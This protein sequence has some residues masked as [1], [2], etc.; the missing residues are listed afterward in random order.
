MTDVTQQPTQLMTEAA[1]NLPGG[2]LVCEQCDWVVLPPSDVQG[3]VICPNCRQAKL[4]PS[5]PRPDGRQ[6]YLR[7]AELTAPFE[8]TPAAVQDAVQQFSRDIPYPPPDLTAANLQSRLQKVFLPAWL[9]DASV[10]AEWQAEVGFN[11]QVVSHQERYSDGADWKTQEV[12]EDRVRWEPRRGRLTRAYQNVRAPALEDAARLNDAIGSY[13]LENIRQ[14]HPSDRQGAFVRL[15]NRSPEDAWV[16]GRAGL[17]ELATEEC[18]AACQADHIR[19]FNWQPNYTGQN[20]TMLLRPALTSFYVDDDG[21]RQPVMINGQTG[22][23]AGKRRASMKAAQQRSLIILAIAAALFIIGIG[24]SA[25]AVLFPPILVV[26][27]LSLGA[28][29]L[30]CAG[31]IFPVASVWWFNRQNPA[32]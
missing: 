19:Q 13:H 15:P 25:A 30:A 29:L 8:A 23:L 9:V 28:G 17:Q 16:D 4:A 3:E 7:P 18:R 26:G 27:L 11:Y 20:W 31:A 10:A 24:L 22:K 32:G 6:A 21:R 14:Y 1:D 12:R 5:T 2:L